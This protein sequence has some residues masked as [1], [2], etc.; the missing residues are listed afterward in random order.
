MIYA[1]AFF[2]AVLAFGLWLGRSRFDVHLFGAR[3]PAIWNRR[4]GFTLIELLVVMAIIAV[5][6]TLTV[7]S[8]RAISDSSRM[9]LAVNTISSTLDHARAH[10]MKSN[11]LA[12]VAFR[13]RL[14]DDEQYIEAVIC[15]HAETERYDSIWRTAD[16]FVPVP[17]LR[18]IKLPAGIGIATPNYH[19][20]GG[21]Y[22]ADFTWLTQ[23]NLA[24]AGT[25][26]IQGERRGVVLAIMYG[27]DG[28][29]L[30]RNSASDTMGAWVDW[31]P[32]GPQD[33]RQSFRGIE[34]IPRDLP[35]A[36]A[37]DLFVQLYDGEEV[38][39]TIASSLA[40]YDRVDAAERAT[41]DWATDVGY[42]ELIGSTDVGSLYFRR[43]II[44]DTG[45]L[46]Y[47]NRYTGIASV[48]QR[49]I[50]PVPKPD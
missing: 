41:E 20:I 4:R 7:T 45:R 15:Q 9:A 3:R 42:E 49:P 2:L 19:D 25:L 5:L 50:D 22:D 44:R 36:S 12:L 21:N 27:P 24:E 46:V 48:R 18:A 37:A 39:V 13:P 40:I 14:D 10:A 30:S 8:V 29:T 38:L 43:G 33:V 28:A 11:D 32:R 1:L 23:I 35:V 34:Y 17:T 26:P 31:N 16:R 6:A 47:F